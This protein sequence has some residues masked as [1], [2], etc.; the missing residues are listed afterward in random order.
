MSQEFDPYHKWLAI[1]A[2]DQPPNHYRLLAIDLFE[3][4]RDVISNASD[5]RMAH[6]RSFQHSEYAPQSQMLLN[7]IAVARG[8]LMNSEQKENYDATLRG[9]HLEVAAEEYDAEEYD[10]EEYDEY[11]EDA[12]SDEVEPGSQS[13]AETESVILRSRAKKRKSSAGKGKW[14]AKAKANAKAKRRMNIFG[15]I[16]APIVGIA[17]GLYI[18]GYIRESDTDN[19]SVVNRPQTS[20]SK[21]ANNSNN[22][23][24]K[25]QP[26]P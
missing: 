14:S 21:P 6:L 15:H 4:D 8:C 2:K 23:V 19:G 9:D 17:L 10:A 13:A 22:E 26:A 16:I 7:K 12:T 18:L 25:E 24:K 11:E 3:S 5:Q 1:P 20:K